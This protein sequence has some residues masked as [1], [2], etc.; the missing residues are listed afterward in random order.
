VLLGLAAPVRFD[1]YV[2]TAQ[3]E[4]PKNSTVL[5]LNP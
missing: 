3:A 4:Q 1:L 5:G 2:V